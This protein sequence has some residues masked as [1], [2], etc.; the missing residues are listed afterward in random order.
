MIPANGAPH[1]LEARDVHRS[2][3]FAQRRARDN[4]NQIG[5]SPNC[6]PSTTFTHSILVER[7]AILRCCITPIEATHSSIVKPDRPGADAIVY[8]ANALNDYV[9]GKNLEAKLETPDF[10]DGGREGIE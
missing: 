10:F 9:L 5:T 2:L 6:R 1:D 7:D 3:S 8:L 4:S